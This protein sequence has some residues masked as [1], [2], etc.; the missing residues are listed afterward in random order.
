MATLEQ[1]VL[2]SATPVDPAVE[3]AAADAVAIDAASLVAELQRA[4]DRDAASETTRRRELIVVDRTLPESSI[5]VDEIE[6]FVAAND[7]ADRL[8]VWIDDTAG[9][10][11]LADL[12]EQ[13][14]ADGPID[15]I[16]LVTHG[17][18]ASV[19]I[20]RDLLTVDTIAA[21]GEALS[22]LGESLAD[23]ADLLLYGCRVASSSD[24]Q[25]LL[26]DLVLLTGADVSASDD[27]TGYAEFGADWELEQT[28]GTIETFALNA[29][30]WR[31]TLLS[32]TFRYDQ[33]NSSAIDG[34]LKVDPRYDD[35]EL[36]VD[37]EWKHVEK[38][39]HVSSQ[40]DVGG[41]DK[42]E[43]ALFKFGQIF[44]N[45]GGDV[46]ANAT[47]TDAKLY[48]YVKNGSDAEFSLRHIQSD[49]GVGS[50]TS[51]IQTVVDQARSDLGIVN[52]NGI[53]KDTWAEFD[54][55]RSL[56]VARVG[57]SFG[58]L[59]ETSGNDEAKFHT[60]N[61]DG[62]NPPPAPI[63]G[64][65]DSFAPVLHIEYETSDYDIVVT[66]TN[67][68]INGTTTSVLDLI[69]LQGGDGISLREA[70]AV[71]ESHN[72]S[73]SQ[74]LKIGFAF[75]NSIATVDGRYE[76]QLTSDLVVADHVG[77]FGDEYELAG[78]GAGVVI[79]AGPHAT[80]GP[81]QTGLTF[82][83]GS[84]NSSLNAVAIVGATDQQVDVRADGVTL[85]NNQFG[86]FLG[87][88]ID[89][90]LL[91]TVG[92]DIS[93][94]DVVV[95]GDEDGN[96]I[97]AI[98]SGLFL[99]DPG[100]V[101]VVPRDNAFRLTDSDG[102]PIRID[103]HRNDYGDADESLAS[104]GLNSPTL[105]GVTSE[106]G[107]SYRVSGVLKI[108]VDSFVDIY[109]VLADGEIGQRLASTVLFR[110]AG[111]TAP[112]EAF[113]LSVT[114]ADA[115]LVGF[116]ALARSIDPADGGTSVFSNTVQRPAATAQSV[117]AVST[118]DPETHSLRPEGGGATRAL[119]TDANGNRGVAWYDAT[120]NTLWFAAYD[121]DDNEL[122]RLSDTLGGDPDLAVDSISLTA[123]PDG[124]FRMLYSVQP[125]AA[126]DYDIFMRTYGLDGTVSP[127]NQIIVAAGDQTDVRVV[128]LAGGGYAVAFRDAQWAGSPIESQ[129]RLRLYD[130]DY[131]GP[132][133]QR[134]ATYVE[135]ADGVGAPTENPE[136]ISLAVAP[137]GTVAVA[138]LDAAA[139]NGSGPEDRIQVVRYRIGSG[140]DASLFASEAA[141][142]TL[143]SVAGAAPGLYA[144]SLAADPDGGWAVAWVENDGG[145]TKLQVQRFDDT[146]AKIGL[147]RLI[148]SNGSRTIA[149]PS[150][151]IDEDS[152]ATIAVNFG[153][154]EYGVETPG[155][156][157]Y[158]FDL[159]SPGGAAAS[160]DYETSHFNAAT[161][162][163]A[164]LNPDQSVS[165]LWASAEQSQ[166]LLATEAAVD[167][168][169]ESVASP[170]LSTPATLELG[171]QLVVDARGTTAGSA[172][173]SQYEYD[174]GY[175]GTFASWMS[176][177]LALQTVPSILF[178]TDSPGTQTIAMRV[179]DEFGRRSAAIIRN[180]EIVS[181]APQFSTDLRLADVT[182]GSTAVFDLSELTAGVDD[183][184]VTVQLTAASSDL[185]ATVVS[186]VDLRIEPVATASTIA[187]AAG[188]TTGDLILKLTYTNTYGDV[189]AIRTVRTRIVGIDDPPVAESFHAGDTV[190]ETAVTI[191]LRRP[192]NGDPEGTPLVYHPE[193]TAGSFGSV[194]QTSNGVVTYTP[195]LDHEG[196]IDFRYRVESNG[197]FSDW[198]TVTVN[199]TPG[200]ELPIAVDYHAG[201]GTEDIAYM[202]DL[203]GAGVF[204][205]NGD[206]LQYE[207]RDLPA[208]HPLAGATAVQQATGS[209]LV[210]FTAGQDCFGEYAF[211]YRAYDT[212]DGVNG[213][214]QWRVAIVD[215]AAVNDPPVASGTDPLDPL[216][217]AATIAED[218][219]LVFDL[220]TL[221]LTD[222]DSASFD[223]DA[224]FV[225]G[226]PVDVEH[227]L[228]ESNLVTITPGDD[229]FGRSR[230]RYRAFDG[231]AWS[232]WATFDIET[233]PVND[234][235]VSQPL[236]PATIFN[237]ESITVRPLD[238]T[239]DVD[240]PASGFTFELATDQPGGGVVGG[241]ISFD[242]DA[243][244][245]TFQPTGGL[246]GTASVAYRI[247]DSMGGMSSL[248]T[249]EID[250]TDRPINTP[251]RLDSP[252]LAT[253]AIDDDGTAPF[254]QA[255]P[256][257]HD[258]DPVT[259]SLDL[260]S[261]ALG[262][263]MNPAGELFRDPA[264]PLG[265]TASENRAL[266]VTFELFDDVNPV[267]APVSIVIEH[268]LTIDS[269]T[270]GP[271]SE[272]A[273]AGEVV[274]R[275]AASTTNPFD[276]PELGVEAFDQTVGSLIP[277][278]ELVERPDGAWDV[279]LTED[280]GGYVDSSYDFRF[281]WCDSAAH[282]TEVA[283]FEVI[284]VNRRPTLLTEQAT[285]QI[286]T[287][288]GRVS[289]SMDD[290]VG[291]VEDLD[292][293]TLQIE[294]ITASE[295][296]RV[297][298]RGAGVFDFEWTDD[299]STEATLQVV[300]T[301]GTL[302]SSVAE[303]TLAREFVAVSE[304]I[305]VPV[306]EPLAALPAP[307]TSSRSMRAATVGAASA[308]PSMPTEPDSM[309]QEES[310]TA[311][312]TAQPAAPA[313]AAPAAAAAVSDDANAVPAVE[314]E[315]ID[316]AEADLGP[317]VERITVDL[318]DAVSSLS[319]DRVA[320]EVADRAVS[321]SSAWQA[322]QRSAA[323]FGDQL[324][325]AAESVA[326]AVFTKSGGLFE[327]LDTVGRDVSGP[328]RAEVLVGSAAATVGGS[329]TV[330]YVLW[331]L[332]SG[333][334]VSGLLAQ[335][336]AWKLI[337]PLVVLDG[338]TGDDDGESLESMIADA[339]FSERSDKTAL[340]PE[341]QG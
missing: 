256:F 321:A 176:T 142:I 165:V 174:L 22:R 156:R 301:D 108:G 4:A 272:H 330:G 135:V 31:H 306:E 188:E 128:E 288:D 214:S 153:R 224:E 169:G 273:L 286:A 212:H 274:G 276:V 141:E 253:M 24:G 122:V 271:I 313:L 302:S 204:D 9:I 185:S 28:L 40:P 292:A 124:L 209:P 223:Y 238:H 186:G 42:T 154:L 21:H 340:H 235:P 161:A 20:G 208:T 195:D 268:D 51:Q 341:A 184:D 200:N 228:S 218:T 139:F 189:S 270:L 151:V 23:D 48:L 305:E 198:R 136:A 275:V 234:D 326:L 104:R 27:L 70:L 74:P 290:F 232:N 307:S 56:Q 269:V 335:M 25:D 266:T 177:P 244:E 89:P 259:L 233:T 172:P 6:A 87:E 201:T 298:D 194:V 121:R 173:I 109:E 11:A 97:A 86:R 55:T 50:S 101:G 100:V 181:V 287:P 16:H 80:G 241:S 67:D 118:G 10:D 168:S 277:P 230:L 191:D 160:F 79:N 183:A 280:A 245:L 41:L 331:T 325:F 297:V 217:I 84:E 337:D 103:G 32:E 291:W 308:A 220:Q 29:E 164:S 71:A 17:S 102:V 62:G 281:G 260:D 206:S 336:P 75:D 333:L 57:G 167:E 30:G 132:G 78:T 248:Q 157:R 2:L 134:F 114:S 284:E 225:S 300:F 45:N 314:A 38:D 295:G 265:L 60:Q 322:T 3:D 88:S 210:T 150:L 255:I 46:P 203:R 19:A 207:I 90:D 264:I 332:R 257:D 229:A 231:E 166:L 18:D 43:T 215:F 190:E 123:T 192:N 125:D 278:L 117:V 130:E 328:E 131:L 63:A 115:G 285:R 58:W 222:V 65:S 221:G 196:T 243:S 258:G 170:S 54:V 319:A 85:T 282:V 317:L 52:T 227:D 327:S 289:L 251:P 311:E 316:A 36:V 34:Y 144:P 14:S 44:D 155:L 26:A 105:T 182:M 246:V 37:R 127:A 93:A 199:V 329:F 95:G 312:T 293:D 113:A 240:S 91:A 339:E 129:L 262:F 249:F 116:A 152:F 59:I 310:R 334:L 119:A 261:A 12:V 72:L 140:E 112:H 126:G 180:V 294:S 211:E 219:P 7:T 315:S 137:D 94:S 303:L 237:D 73:T 179:V 66:N 159:H 76:I 13:A 187:L 193:A 296:G 175:N 236:P 324:D 35:S 61:E 69:A 120:T 299:V 279:V 33:S 106:G 267:R 197:L 147:P 49:W 15:A 99:S 216:D 5:L 158:T 83:A 213:Y 226:M 98:S 250:V 145:S 146:L 323:Q 171:E 110:S 252:L 318:F 163:T 39:V 107:D 320:R 247:G 111:Q 148:A 239:T 47:I 92:V 143:P 309:Q 96:A 1:R 254:Y 304:P 242:P 133:G 263:F 81:R 338:L 178:D 149:S 138:Y 8:I 283:R 77:I 162:P 205:E 53:V 82:A 202:V 68:I 64:L